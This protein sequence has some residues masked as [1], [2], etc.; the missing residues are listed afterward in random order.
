MIHPQTLQYLSELNANNNRDWFAENK[1]RYDAVRKHNEKFIN[2]LIHELSAIDKDLQHLEAKDCVFR[3]YRDTR[4][5]KDKTPYKTNMGAYMAKGGRKGIHAGYYLHMEPG[6]SFLAGGLYVPEPNVLKA[7]RN[8]IVA[9]PDE[10]GKI[11]LDAKFV[12][13]FGKLEGEQLK[14]TP[15]GFP[16]DFAH[17]EWLKLKSFNTMHSI[18]DEQLLSDSFTSYALEIFSAMLPLNRFFN[19]LIDDLV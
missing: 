10:F 2:K 18:S 14:K 5:G 3:I 9:L 16:K 12:K 4:F 15:T 17:P 6:A 13:L 7:V 1:D 8:E 19:Q 11:V